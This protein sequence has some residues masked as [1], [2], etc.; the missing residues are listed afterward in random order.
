[1]EPALITLM[2]DFTYNKV[3]DD[4]IICI[5]LYKD[6][7]DAT[8]D[9]HFRVMNAKDEGFDACLY[10]PGLF[11]PSYK[12]EAELMVSKSG[13]L[14]PTYHALYIHNFDNRQP[15]VAYDVNNIHDANF[16]FEWHTKGMFKNLP[17]K[18]IPS[19]LVN[20]LL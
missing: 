12:H 11:K 7:S 17:L 5:T 6:M 16:I 8:E 4:G 9:Y 3:G 1:M 10:K 19:S 13:V 14:K 2:K 18:Y 20:Y 15:L